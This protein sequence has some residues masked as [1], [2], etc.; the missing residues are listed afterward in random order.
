MIRYKFSIQVCILPATLF[1]LGL[2][3]LSKF[4][5]VPLSLLQDLL[6]LLSL[7]ILSCS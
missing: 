7:V 4:P 3:V 5:I 6:V 1:T 2:A